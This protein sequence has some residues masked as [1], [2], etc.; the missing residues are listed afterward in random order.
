MNRKAFTLI[1]LL[2]VIAIIAI[3][4]A[5]L[6]PVFAQAREKARQAACGS[7]L[8]QVGLAFAQYVQDYDETTP[9]IWFGPNS[10]DQRYFWMDALLPYTKSNEFFSSCPSKDF[11][12]WQPS[13]Q[14]PTPGANA[15]ARENVSF[16]VNSLYASA[17]TAAKTADKQDTTPPIRE[18]GV[19]YS[20]FV[21]PTNT[22]L[23]GDGSGY[24]IAYSAS[25]ADLKVE[26]QPP[27][28]G[29]IK[30]PNLGRLTPVNNPNRFIGRHFGGANFVYC[31]GHAKW[32]KISDVA[33]TNSN[34]VLHLFTIEDDENK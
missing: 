25:N 31:D 16:A 13:Q 26:T 14:I 22:V 6:F 23:G 20:E 9:Q 21:V 8:R 12:N 29:T 33:K 32:S 1:E 7:G 5:I 15:K 18:T 27:Y 24:Y 30:F 11:D 19:P 2:V 4:A 10:M 17:N 3:L 28:T 34:G